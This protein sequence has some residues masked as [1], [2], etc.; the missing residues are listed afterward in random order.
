MNM[1]NQSSDEMVAEI[2]RLRAENTAMQSRPKK[3]YVKKT[4][5]GLKVSEKGGISLYGMG[6]FPVTLYKQQ[7]IALL[8]KAEEIQKFI[9]ENES[10]LAVKDKT[11]VVAAS[12]IA[13]ILAED[14][15]KE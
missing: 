12:D 15:V 9:A 5:G 1:N 13:T 14:I 4:V 8:A 10:K 2:A 3:G 11:E 7:W 6:R